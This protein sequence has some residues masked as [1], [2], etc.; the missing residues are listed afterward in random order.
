MRARI[1]PEKAMRSSLSYVVR[2]L[3]RVIQRQTLWI[4]YVRRS[5]ISRSPNRWNRCWQL[6]VLR[7][8]FIL[9]D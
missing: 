3:L 5:A 8:Y 2:A 1:L 4:E 9:P 7:C 6:S